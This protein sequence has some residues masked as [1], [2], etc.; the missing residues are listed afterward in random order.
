MGKAERV[1]PTP[2][3]KSDLTVTE[4]CAE[5]RVARSTVWRL[6]ARGE[7]SGYSVGTHMKLDRASVDAF[8]DRNRYQPVLESDVA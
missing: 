4:A 5:M 7:I 3:I 6:L 8:K 1:V 2:S